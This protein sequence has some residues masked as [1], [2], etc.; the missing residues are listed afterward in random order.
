[1]SSFAEFVERSGTTTGWNSTA[2][3]GLIDLVFSQQAVC[4]TDTVIDPPGPHVRFVNAAYLDLFCC[5]ESDVIGL[6]PRVSQSVLT[7]PAVL[8]RV[9]T[10]LESRRSVRAQAIN[11][12]FDGDA[13]RLRWTIDPIV[14]DN[15]SD[16]FVALMSDI[17]LEDRL[18]RRLIA[19][20]TLLTELAPSATTSPVVDVLTRSIEPF[21]AEIGS[22]TVR[23]GDRVGESDP[24]S[25]GPEPS[26]HRLV[27][28]LPVGEHGAVDIRVH[29]EATALFDRAGVAELCDRAS[30]IVGR[31]DAL[32][33]VS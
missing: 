22:A 17:T 29:T 15:G 19:V 13:F 26:E 18:R 6:S 27:C 11:R 32:D 31:T 21:V 23:W 9:R 20:D 16:R 3:A 8:A 1:M 4:V 14:D 30:W 5:E 2:D 7:D 33:L 10:A 25:A 24:A 12:R 28:R